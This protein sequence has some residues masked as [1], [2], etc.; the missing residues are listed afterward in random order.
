MPSGFLLNIASHAV[1]LWNFDDQQDKKRMRC[2]LESELRF[3]ACEAVTF[4]S[5]SEKQ[6]LLVIIHENA[7]VSAIQLGKLHQRFVSQLD[8]ASLHSNGPQLTQWN[9]YLVPF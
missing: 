8:D 9:R 5:F 6:N 1:Q 4:C 3:K 2:R 7:S